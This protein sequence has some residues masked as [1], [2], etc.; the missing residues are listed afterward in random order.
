[1]LDL[2]NAKENIAEQLSA[3]S[4]YAEAI[5]DHFRGLPNDDQV[6]VMT[7]RAGF[8]AALSIHDFLSQAVE[9][10]CYVN[11]RELSFVVDTEEAAALD[12]IGNRWECSRNEAATRLIRMTLHNLLLNKAA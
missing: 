7:Q 10:V 11:R 9:M 5:L 12:L 2:T 4:F 3:A 6:G 8:A 1:M